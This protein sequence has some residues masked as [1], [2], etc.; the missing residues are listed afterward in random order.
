MK[1]LV[2]TAFLLLQMTA[3]VQSLSCWNCTTE[4]HS[5]CGDTFNSAG[6]PTCNGDT[7]SKGY[8]RQ[9]GQTVVVRSCISTVATACTDVS[10]GGYN[11]RTCFCNT[12]LC[13]SQSRPQH[14][15][16][17]V[18]MLAFIAVGAVFIDFKK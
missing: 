5:G 15:Q 10:I 6:L 4:S 17:F 18:L 13:N 16:V 14:C 9:S 8:T 7:C 11:V 3:A 2:L 1:S 12:D